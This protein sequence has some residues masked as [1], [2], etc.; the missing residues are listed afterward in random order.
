MSLR[1]TL[2][3]LLAS[4]MLATT[5]FFGQAVVAP[6]LADACQQY[7]NGYYRS[8]GTYVSGYYRTCPNSSRTD[9]YSYPGNY[10]PNTG[11]VTGGSY[12]SGGSYFTTPT[13][14]YPSYSGGY[15]SSYSWR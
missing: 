9:N 11:R 7:V 5:M 3:L 1:R 2:G 12:Y 8:N 6:D 15:Y 10:N 13:Y 4:T 14:S